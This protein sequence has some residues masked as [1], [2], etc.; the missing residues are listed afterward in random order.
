MPALRVDVRIAAG[1]IG[2]LEKADKDDIYVRDRTLPDNT[3]HNLYAPFYEAYIPA[4]GPSCDVQR[5]L[6]RRRRVRVEQLPRL[7]ERAVGTTTTTS[8]GTGRKTR[9]AATTR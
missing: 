5:P 2:S 7:P 4:A 3:P 9:P 8:S 6:R 1:G